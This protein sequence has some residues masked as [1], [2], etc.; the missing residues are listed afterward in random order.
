MK[1]FAPVLVVVASLLSIPSTA[2]AS[3]TPFD[4]YCS[5]TGDFCQG[6]YRQGGVRAKLSTFSFRGSYELCVRS[7][8]TG[9]D[10]K[11]F[12]LRTSSDGI[13]VG[14]VSLARHFDI[15]AHGRYA[16][17]WTYGGSRIGKKLHFSK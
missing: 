2:P 16:V 13:Y 3:P 8:R 5:P 12:Q 15:G 1:R 9:N 4:S 17:A 11:R 7:R 14:S 10:C 6:L